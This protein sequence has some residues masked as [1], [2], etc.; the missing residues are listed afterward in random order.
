VRIDRLFSRVLWLLVALSLP[1]G[2]IA[3]VAA[4]LHQLSDHA[5]YLTCEPWEDGQHVEAARPG[6][7]HETPCRLCHGASPHLQ[8][9]LAARPEMVRPGGSGPLGRAIDQI[10]SSQLQRSSLLT[11]GP[12]APQA[13]SHA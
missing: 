13:A 9:N 12:P 5:E 6:H 4:S 8:L 11:R 10:R 7:L 1:A 3:R 2:E